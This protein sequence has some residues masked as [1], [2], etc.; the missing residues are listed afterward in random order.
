LGRVCYDLLN[1]V[2]LSAGLGK[3]RAE[4]Q[5]IFTRHLS[6]TDVGDVV[7][8]DRGYTAY[9]VMAFW[10]AHRRELVIR[11]SRH[12]LAVVEPFWTSPDREQ[13]VT[14]VM[15]RAQRRFV[16]TQGLA[17]SRQVR[18]IKVVLPTGQREVLAT[19]VLDPQAY[20]HAALQRV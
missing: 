18:L 4:K 7:A 2:A 6:A 1:H 13:I 8:L 15:P 3:K 14:L 16:T 11:L 5:F 20:P 19:S 17:T 12:S 9:G 10:Q